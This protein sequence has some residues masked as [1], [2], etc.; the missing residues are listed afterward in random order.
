[1][2]N[3]GSAWRRSQRVLDLAHSLG[4]RNIEVLGFRLRAFIASG[5]GWRNLTEEVA[6]QVDEIA[7]SIGEDEAVSFSALC[8]GLFYFGAEEWDT[9][10]KFLSKAHK[11]FSRSGQPTS[12]LKARIYLS[13]LNFHRGHTESAIDEMK[14]ILEI[15]T[16]QKVMLLNPVARLASYAIDSPTEHAPQAAEILLGFESQGRYLD[17]V[18]WGYLGLLDRNGQKQIRSYMLNAVQRI[19]DSLD[20]VQLRREFLGFPRTRKALLAIQR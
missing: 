7:D 5:V 18:E 15:S 16:S 1:M 2:G 6:A 11:G 8:R 17:L 9:A 19:A 20:D 13:L 10:E 3:V 4:D 14:E 12:D